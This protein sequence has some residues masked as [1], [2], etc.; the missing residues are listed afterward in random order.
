MNLSHAVKRKDQHDYK[1]KE[2]KATLSKLA[3]EWEQAGKI[4]SEA[5]EDILF[6]LRKQ[7]FSLWKP[8]ILIIDRDKVKTRLTQVEMSKRAG[9]A[10][11]YIIADLSQ[12]EFEIIEP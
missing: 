9:L 4:N 8:L 2:Q 3:L 10:P 7:D 1:I 6:L 12:D 11:E 5:K